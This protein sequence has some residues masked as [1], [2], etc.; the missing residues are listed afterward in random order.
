MDLDNF[1]MKDFFEE[2]AGKHGARIEDVEGVEAFYVDEIT[3]KYEDTN[4]N[5]SITGYSHNAYLRFDSEEAEMT[6]HESVNDNDRSYTLTIDGRLGL[7]SLDAAGHEEFA[8]AAEEGVKL[9]DDSP[10]LDEVVE[11][12]YGL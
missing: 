3:V 5:E 9:D 10:D 11:C 12:V 2:L 7:E 8:L 1:D 4:G 6:L